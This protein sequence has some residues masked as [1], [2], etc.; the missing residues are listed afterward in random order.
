MCAK[1]D[2]LI[3]SREGVSESRSLL[4]MQYD[5]LVAGNGFVR[6]PAEVSH[7]GVACATDVDSQVVACCQSTSGIDHEYW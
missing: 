5:D 3:V 7:D 6:R 4:T 2:K 1:L